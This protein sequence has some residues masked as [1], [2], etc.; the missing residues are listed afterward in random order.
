MIRNNVYYQ[1]NQMQQQR[2]MNVQQKTKTPKKKQIRLSI[3]FKDNEIWLYDE[4]KKYSC[5]SAH[6]KDI[7][8]EHFSNKSE[9]EC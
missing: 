5:P 4:L 3:S 7:L 8:S 9:K 1:Q 6:V 2:N